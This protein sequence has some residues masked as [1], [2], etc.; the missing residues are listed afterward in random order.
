M[1]II[2]VFLGV[3]LPDGIIIFIWSDQDWMVKSIRL[4]NNGDLGVN[5]NPSFLIFFIENFQLGAIFNYTFVIS[6]LHFH[7][8][9]LFFFF[10][11][12]L[13]FNS[14][15]TLRLEYE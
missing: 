10:L 7:D 8:V 13:L 9:F 12:Y 14:W 2:I 6:Y 15:V 11:W 5:T 4:I 1:G 3:S